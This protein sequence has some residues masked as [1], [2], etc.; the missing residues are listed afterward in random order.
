MVLEGVENTQI[1]LSAICADE[2]L[3]T[4]STGFV[5]LLERNF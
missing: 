5:S 3:S 1:V 2:V 4:G